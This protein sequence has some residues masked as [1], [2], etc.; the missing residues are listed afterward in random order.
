MPT[1]YFKPKP[2]RYGV[3]PVVLEFQAGVDPLTA[4]ATVN[5]ILPL[6]GRCRFA[7][8]TC[9]QRTL[10]ADA[11]G[12]VLAYVKKMV[13]GSTSTTLTDALD[14]EAASAS[15][16]A[17]F[18]P[19]AGLTE[20]QRTFAAVDNVYFSVVNNSA[21]INTQPVG[22]VFLVELELVE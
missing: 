15:Y 4:N 14:L 22:L 19:V 10:A 2:G 8:A 1:N 21:A 17:P 16:T 6:P 11:D 3:Q 12:T 20:A 13:G 5:F 18:V 7:R 9:L